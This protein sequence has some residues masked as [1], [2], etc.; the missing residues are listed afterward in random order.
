[1]TEIYLHI[2]ARMAD[3]IMYISAR[4]RTRSAILA[5]VQRRIERRLCHSPTGGTRD[6]GVAI[7]PHST[8][9]VVPDTNRRKGRSQLP[10]EFCTNMRIRR[11]PVNHVIQLR[12]RQI[13]R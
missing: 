5:T 4:T 7:A 12:C 9:V 2:D 3:Y 1:M 6:G 8:A 13:G 10:N 11:M